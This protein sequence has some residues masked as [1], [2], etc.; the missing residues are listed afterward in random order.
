MS[1]DGFV[2]KK[3]DQLRWYLYETTVD[4]D[5]AEL[6]DVF[7][8]GEA[9]TQYWIYPCTYEDGITRVTI[10]YSVSGGG[11]WLNISVTSNDF[12]VGVDKILALPMTPEIKGILEGHKVS[13][14]E[15]ITQP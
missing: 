10:D 4:R 1:K 3:I 7:I 15:K 12:L 13:I 8:S 14:V 11:G 9:P 2:I 5:V 6:Y